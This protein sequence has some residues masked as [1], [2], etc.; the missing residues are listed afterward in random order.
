MSEQNVPIINY[1]RCDRCGECIIACP[2]DA[3]QMTEEGL[4]FTHPIVCT[5]C[6]ICES[7]CPQNAIRAPLTVTWA[8]GE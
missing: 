8:P 7:V 4:A 6:T 5:Y 3:L 1:A 2:E